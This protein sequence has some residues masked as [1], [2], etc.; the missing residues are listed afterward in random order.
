MALV[1]VKRI[2]HVAL[3]VTDVDAQTDFYCQMAGFGKTTQDAVGR[4]YLRCNAD[5]HSLVLVPAEEPSLD[6]YALDVGEPTELDKA[7][8]ALKQA[9]IPIEFNGSNELGHGP[10]VRLQD[11]DGFTVELV[12]GLE[13]VSPTYG[14]R[15]VQ[16]R[17]LAHITLLSDD[18]KS[19][20]DFYQNVLGFRVS[21]WLE[22]DFIWLRCN[23]EH[24]SLAI[25]RLNRVGLHHVAYDVVDFT[26]LVHQADH[27]ARHGRSLLYGP[28]R[29]GPGHNQF[30]YFQDLDN[31]IVEFTCDS[32]QIWDDE[33]YEPMRWSASEK[34]INVW[35]QDPPPEFFE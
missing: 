9:G 18:P 28:G 21:D 31:Q 32:L 22:E 34:W 15:A 11:P 2:S 10:S 29:H 19:S 24:H 20:A 16:P 1:N 12:S 14:I 13:Q 25:A 4:V 35:G 8:N 33:A 30:A 17:R 26:A 5:H 6:H 3:K 7:A 23:P 27:L